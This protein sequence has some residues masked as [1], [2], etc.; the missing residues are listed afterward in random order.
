MFFASRKMEDRQILMILSATAALS[1]GYGLI[2]LSTLFNFEIEYFS[3]SSDLIVSLDLM[4]KAIG[5]VLS[6]PLLHRASSLQF[7]K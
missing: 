4:T 3:H 6:F 2:P 7:K 5:G 1:K